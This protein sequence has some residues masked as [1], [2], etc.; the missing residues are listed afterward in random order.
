VFIDLDRLTFRTERGHR[1][2]LVLT[3]K[4]IQK[5]LGGRPTVLLSG[6]GYHIYQPVESFV[7][8]QQEL[9]SKFDQPSKSFIR[10]A[11]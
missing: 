4:N 8:E 6:N 11:E 1:L 2:A 9:F 10:F 3:I 7:L 5:K